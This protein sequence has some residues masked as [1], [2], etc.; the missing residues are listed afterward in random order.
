LGGKFAHHLYTLGPREDFELV[1]VVSQPARPVGRGAQLQDP[2]VAAWAK[3]QNLTCLQPESARSQDFL[4]ELESLKPDVIVTAAYGQILSESFLKIPRRATINIHPS[5]LP[6]YRGAT[7]VP[8]A[9]LDNLTRTAVT[10]LFTVKKLDAGAIIVQ[11]LFDISPTERAG[12]LT[13]RLFE[14]SADMLLQALQKLKD[15][16]FTGI[17]QNDAEAT[18]CRKIEKD[19]GEIDWTLPSQTIFN[20]FRAYDPWP[21]SWTLLDQKRVVITE[22]ELSE[23]KG[24]GT[25][26][27]FRWNKPLKAL[28]VTTGEGALLIKSLKPAGSKLMDAAAFWNGLKLDQDDRQF[29]KGSAAT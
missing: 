16:G 27:T 29:S 7:P 15:P 12:P 18:F 21:G 5:Q 20:K 22:M 3:S 8:S 11:K 28:V 13:A 24:E 14:E 1:A 17:P 9:L 6:M 19:A 2:P 23:L 10:I 26:G 25:P 4:D